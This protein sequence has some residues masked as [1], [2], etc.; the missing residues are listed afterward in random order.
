M[1]S[2]RWY[3]KERLLEYTVILAVGKNN[4]ICQ[5]KHDKHFK[6]WG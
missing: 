5:E 1:R 4:L 3:N 6:S 2:F